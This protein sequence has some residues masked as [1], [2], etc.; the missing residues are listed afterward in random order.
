M[1][2]STWEHRFDPIFFIYVPVRAVA[3]MFHSS[4][5]MQY[6]KGS[7]TQEWFIYILT[8]CPYIL[9]TVAQDMQSE[10]WKHTFWAL[11]FDVTFSHSCLLHIRLRVEGINGISRDIT[12]HIAALKST[13]SKTPH[14]SPLFLF[15]VLKRPY[16]KIQCLSLRAVDSWHAS[17]LVLLVNTT[18]SLGSSYK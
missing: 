15:M 3:Y 17:L 8:Y 2:V 16:V 4:W 7:D 18:P 11:I 1:W 13:L 9:S 12:K 5:H 14:A 6:W 10:A